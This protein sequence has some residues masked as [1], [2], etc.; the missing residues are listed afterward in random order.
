M[1][2]CNAILPTRPPTTCGAQRY[3]CGGCGAV[4]CA[5]D[6]TCPRHNFTGTLAHPKCH[7]C[8]ASRRVAV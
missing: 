3:R 4:G 6:P 2:G 8:G 7:R 1:S 5:A